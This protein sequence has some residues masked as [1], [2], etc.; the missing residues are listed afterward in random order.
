MNEKGT[1]TEIRDSGAAAPD[2]AANGVNRV[3]SARPQ[4]HRIRHAFAAMLLVLSAVIGTGLVAS[5]AEA[6]TVRPGAGWGQV[7]VLLDS[8]ETEQ[9]R[10][11]YWAATVICWNSGIGGKLLSIG[12]CQ[13]AVT[14][15]AARAYY[16]S[17]R[18]RAGMTVTVWGGYWCWRY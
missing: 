15:C 9:A 2:M 10:R 14:V 1:L 4:S 8:Y 11:S 16:S 12:V 3:Q 17:P 13:T 5:P 7:D 6:V 18:M